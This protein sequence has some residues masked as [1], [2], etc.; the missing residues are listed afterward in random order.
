MNYD[1]YSYL[2]DNSTP[3][4]KLVQY[5][6]TQEGISYWTTDLL[7]EFIKQISDL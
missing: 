2:F 5:I 3:E 6:N 4:D 7:K 1:K